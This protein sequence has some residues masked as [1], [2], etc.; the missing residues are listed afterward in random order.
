MNRTIHLK[1]WLAFAFLILI[2]PVIGQ[3]IPVSGTWVNLPYQDVRNKYMNPIYVDFTSP[4]F[5]KTKINEQ[6][7][8]GM[9]YIVIMAVA[10]EQKSFYPSD[11][12]EPA[13]DRSKDS[14]VET[15]L[16]TA[17]KR[18]VKVFLSCG[19]AIDQDDNLRDPKIRGLQL[20]IMEE[21][22]N[23]FANHEAFYGWYLP[24]EDSMEPFLSDHAVEAVNDLTK[25]ARAFTPGKKIMV[26]PYGICHAN[27]DDPKFGEQINK[28][29]VDIIAYQDEIGCVRE[30][31]PL[32]RMKENFAKL[33]KIHKNNKIAFWANVESFTWEKGDNSRESALIP[34]SFSRYLSQMA[35]VSQ[36]GVS[37]VISF[38]TYGM[39]DKP[40]SEYPIGQP[41]YANQVYQDFMDWQNGDLRWKLLEKT[42]YNSVKS[43][44]ISRIYDAQNKD[45]KKLY[46]SKL[47]KEADEDPNWQVIS[48]QN[49]TLFGELP[50]QSSLN[51]LMIRAFNYGPKKIALPKA[52]HLYLSTN[53][54]D[55]KRVSSISIDQFTNNRFD[56]W[57]DIALLEFAAT[58]AKYFKIEFDLLEGTQ[59]Y[60]D[61]VFVNAK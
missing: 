9:K 59:L 26:S 23:K 33:K 13:Y 56:A 28:L 40:N 1:I 22:G 50:K 2:K 25:R 30:P 8:L 20:K 31:Q 49:P 41:V 29:T 4:E 46:D 16:G 17:A 11:F 10:D 34:A 18:G 19:W 52:V 14:P 48:G 58:D 44:K 12:M 61:E 39:Y 47:A 32:P 38:S 55:F 43:D 24:V 42:F 37:E 27:L 45:L 60:V 5:W 7:D 3:T 54:T 57:L 36:A 21:L 51:N 15:I 6:A 35:G 53:N